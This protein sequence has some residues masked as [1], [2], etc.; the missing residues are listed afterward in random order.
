RWKGRCVVIWLVL[1]GVL[2]VLGILST[3]GWTVDSRDDDQ[4]LWPLERR[5]PG[6]PPS[7][8]ARDDHNVRGVRPDVALRRACAS[9]PADETEDHYERCHAR[10]SR[11]AQ[12]QG[13]RDG[14]FRRPL[15]VHP[16]AD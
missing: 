8:P 5:Q 1:V 10:A 3:L 15:R 6:A 4:K 11:S 2:A 16:P 7:A 14:G 12:R 13:Q 9:Y